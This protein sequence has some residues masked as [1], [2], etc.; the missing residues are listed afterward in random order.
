MKSEKAPTVRKA[1]YAMT[2]GKIIGEGSYRRVFRTRGSRWV[3][4]VNMTT[5]RI[6]SNDL[7]WRTYL[8]Y[9]NSV[10]LPEGVK[11]PEMH[12][13]NGGI[14][15][16]EYIEGVHPENECYKDWHL[17]KGTPDFDGPFCPGVDKCWAEKIKGIEISD[18]HYENVLVANDGTI[19]LIDLGHGS[20]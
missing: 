10:T 11:I 4:K 2:H 16:S 13:L 6:G 20:S 17:T 8:K 18:L 7:E 19:Y 15:A 12:Y 5:H 3:Y 9:A 14:I 1:H